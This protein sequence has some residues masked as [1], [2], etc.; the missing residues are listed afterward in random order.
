M[1]KKKLNANR[2][3]TPIEA[4]TLSKKD[5]TNLKQ[6]VQIERENFE[7]TYNIKLDGH[8]I[9]TR[10]FI[11]EITNRSYSNLTILEK[12]ILLANAAFPSDKEIA[13][14]LSENGFTINHLKAI[15]RFRSLI[16]KSLVNDKKMDEE[17]STQFEIYKKVVSKL[18][19]LFNANFKFN[20]STIIL[21]RICEMLVTCP[22]LF[23]VKFKTRIK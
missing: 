18:L 22:E 1:S 13:T 4:S 23:E 21:N 14:L 19:D 12:E 2:I 15:I 10:M 16:K 20:N 3:L 17:L 11:F 9:T 6:L 8:D 7:K 5:Y